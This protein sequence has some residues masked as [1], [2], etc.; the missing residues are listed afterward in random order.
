[1]FGKYFQQKAREVSEGLVGAIAQAD[2][3]GFSEADIA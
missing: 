1:M 3:E 2:P